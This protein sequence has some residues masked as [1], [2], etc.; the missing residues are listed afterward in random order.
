MSPPS[1]YNEFL[2]IARRPEEERSHCKFDA[3]ANASTLIGRE[4]GLRVK[5][6]YAQPGLTISFEFFPPKSAE[7]E[8]TLYRDTVPALKVLG[9]QFVSVTYGAGGGTRDS[10]L[11]IVNRLR[12]DFGIEAMSHL[13]CV[14]STRDMLAKYLDEAQ[15]SG[16]ENIL[17][18]RGDPPKGQATFTPVEGGFAHSV[19]LIRLV[20]SR[21]C[22]SVGGACYPEGHIECPD[23]HQ[24]WD[25]A[26]AKVDAGADFLI[27][28][29]F[30]DERDFLQMVDYLRHKRS[31]KVPIVPGVLPFL[32]A[33]Q[34][35]RFASLCGA[36]LPEALAR[37]LEALAQDDEAV[38]RLGVEVC[39]DI[40]SKLIA[41][42]IPGIHFYCLN[43]VPSCSEIVQNLGLCQ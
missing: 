38:R 21:N 22:F 34:I 16:I 14:G 11:R 41:H 35:K 37:K 12:R 27:S 10:T 23:K 25:R 39:T 6:L 8:N 2:K 29:L 4:S 15:A 42:G 19:D 18:L 13:T 9:P 1:R 24:D 30:Y 43:R 32:S 5:E 28:Q 36:K 20:K 17:C 40:C 31:V 33:E 7:A 3:S 26:A